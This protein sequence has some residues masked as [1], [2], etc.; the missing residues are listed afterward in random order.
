MPEDL[1][2]CSVKGDLR[3]WLLWRFLFRSLVWWHFLLAWLECLGTSCT[4]WLLSWSPCFPNVPPHALKKASM[5]TWTNLPRL[6]H[7]WMRLPPCILWSLLHPGMML[8]Q[9]TS[10]RSCLSTWC[11]C[12]LPATIGFL[13]RTLLFLSSVLCLFVAPLFVVRMDGNST[14]GTLLCTLHGATALPLHSFVTLLCYAARQ[15]PVLLAQLE[16]ALHGSHHLPIGCL[17]PH[18]AAVLPSTLCV[19]DMPSNSLWY[20]FLVDHCSVP[21]DNATAVCCDRLGH[22]TLGCLLSSSLQLSSAMDV[23]SHCTGGEDSQ[24]HHGEQHALLSCS[25][26]GLARGP[27]LRELCLCYDVSSSFRF[28]HAILLGTYL[29]F[30]SMRDFVEPFLLHFL[31]HALCEV[32]PFAFSNYFFSV[33]LYTFY[34][35]HIYLYL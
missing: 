10:L 28:W 26:D 21:M 19:V 9:T 7:R 27:C 5:S 17:L 22:W 11:K 12:C 13:F 20:P 3:S 35:T 25:P 2:C 32:F 8:T 4:L 15:Q 24:V 30:H 6:R 34:F 14:T 16:A 33:Y 31:F 1:R 29:S 18:L 23:S